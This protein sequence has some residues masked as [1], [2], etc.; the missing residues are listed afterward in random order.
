MNYL[1]D[2]C[3][4]S[5]LV[6]TNPH[7]KVIHWIKACP[8]ESLYLSSLTIGELQKGVSKLEASK[9]R[10]ELQ[11][12]IDRDLQSRFAGRII[13][14]DYPVAQK[15]GQ[16]QAAA[17]KAG[18]PLPVLDGLIASIALTHNLIVVTRNIQDIMASGAELFNPW[19]NSLLKN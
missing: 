1:L 9:K 3:V 18:K 19:Q 5:E 4:I 7:Q 15:W 17:E 2:T 12:W 16:V 11:Q 14:V 8:E 13:S 6:K 10:T